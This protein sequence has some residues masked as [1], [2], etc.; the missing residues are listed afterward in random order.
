MD[1]EIES[2]K[3]KISPL[4]HGNGIVLLRIHKLKCRTCSQRFRF[5]S[6]ANDIAKF[7]VGKLLVI[8][9]LVID[10]G[11]FEQFGVKPEDFN[12]KSA[13]FVFF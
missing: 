1:L 4:T 9:L 3:N 11:H 2:I 7:I 13:L 12:L 8:R 6:I 5:H 10:G